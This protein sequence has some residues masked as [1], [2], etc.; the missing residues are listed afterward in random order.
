MLHAMVEARVA[1]LVGLVLLIVW[2]VRSST[3]KPDAAA[4][5]LME[6]PLPPPPSG[7]WYADPMGRFEQR[8][9]SGEE[10]TS[11]VVLASGQQTTV[12]G[13]GLGQFPVVEQLSDVEVALW[14]PLATPM[15]SARVLIARQASPERVTLHRCQTNTTAA[16]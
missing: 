4:A 2:A 8:W 5:G 10:W 7:S 16:V 9:W 11:Q 1:C 13:D 15:D 12:E 6:S 14:K 3:N